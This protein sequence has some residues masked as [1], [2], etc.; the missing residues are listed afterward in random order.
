MTERV[1]D[2]LLSTPRGRCCRYL[3][4]SRD[5]YMSNATAAGRVPTGSLPHCV[6]RTAVRRRVELRVVKVIGHQTAKPARDTA[7]V[8]GLILGAA[9]VS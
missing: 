3:L 4:L 9:A 2:T 5:E 1:S 8:G 7:V 6:T